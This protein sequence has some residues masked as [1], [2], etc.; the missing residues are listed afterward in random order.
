PLPPKD[1]P[2]P[3]PPGDGPCKDVYCTTYVAQIDL[4]VVNGAGAHVVLDAFHTEDMNGNILP[5][6]LN[7]Y[8]NITQRY[9]VFNDFWVTG[10]QNTNI[11][12]RF[13][14]YKGGQ[15]VVDEVYDIHTD[16]CHIAK[17]SGTNIVVVP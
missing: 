6:N 5:S 16:C 1:T 3:P 12:V 10:H 4:E 14:G 11:Q 13:V 15:K 7:Y 9:I 8:D 17:T 2:P